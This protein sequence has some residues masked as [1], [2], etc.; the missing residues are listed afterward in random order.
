MKRRGIYDGKY[1]V[2]YFLCACESS[3]FMTAVEIQQLVEKLIR[4]W[5][6]THTIAPTD[7]ISKFLISNDI[8]K[9]VKKV[10]DAQHQS[11]N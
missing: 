7:Q 9:L 5:E 11:Q 8:L 2:R 6:E 3:T 1:I 4:R 10:K